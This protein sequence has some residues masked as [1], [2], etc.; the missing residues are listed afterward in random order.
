MVLVQLHRRIRELLE[1]ADHLAAGATAGSLVRTLGMKPFRVEKLVGQARRWTLAELD[2][3][4]EGL[5]DLDAHGE[6]RTRLGGDRRAAHGWRSASGS[7][8]ASRRWRRVRP[9]AAAR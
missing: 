8:S 7:G 6:G 9:A 4:L 5:L 2:D 3:A 1:V